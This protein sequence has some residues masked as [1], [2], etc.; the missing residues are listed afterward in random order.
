MEYWHCSQSGWRRNGS[1]DAA[2]S[3][4]SSETSQSE[5][6]RGTGTLHSL[7]QQQKNRYLNFKTY[8]DNYMIKQQL[9]EPFDW[10]T[11]VKKRC[12][13]CLKVLLKWSVT[14]RGSWT[15]RGAG[16][17]E[18][19]PHTVCWEPLGPALSSRKCASSPRGGW[20]CAGDAPYDENTLLDL[21]WHSWYLL[22]PWGCLRGLA[23]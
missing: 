19:W 12:I 10:F 1:R 3:C 21:A 23:G 22:W 17:G 16:C 9:S 13:N 20:R 11:A 6:E 15:A 5:T 4:T 2:P 14:Y 7:E 18:Q 8:K